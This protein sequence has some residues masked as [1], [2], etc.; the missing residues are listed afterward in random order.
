[1]TY[2]LPLSSCQLSRELLSFIKETDKDS[3][4]GEEYLEIIKEKLDE[5]GIEISKLAKD[6][7]KLNLNYE[8]KLYLKSKD[9]LEKLINLSGVA[10]V[11][12]QLMAV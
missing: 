8:D 2:E 7:F 3:A 5:K 12:L 10:V 6:A 4:L 1:M 11:K 9:A